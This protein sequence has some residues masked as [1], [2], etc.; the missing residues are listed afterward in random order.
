[1]TGIAPPGSG[2][3]EVRLDAAVA[4]R[5]A[6]LPA[7]LPATV[8]DP[9]SVPEA[10][11][12]L[13]AWAHSVDEWDPQT[14]DATKRDQIRASIDAH[15]AKGTEAGVRG[16]LD[17]VGASYDY[18]ER[19]DGDPFTARIVIENTNELR[20]SAITGILDLIGSY[21]RGTVDIEAELRQGIS[22]DLALAGGV[23]GVVVATVLDLEVA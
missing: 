13:L 14:D 23:G 4:E 19:P 8:W 5:I 1:M 11:L 6:R 2:S 3:A 18:V 7:G 16:V 9:G 17:R 12:A 20:L 10:Y 22:T 15:R 21:Q